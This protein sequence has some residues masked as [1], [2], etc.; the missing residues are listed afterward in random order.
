M[1][2]AQVPSTKKGW[3]LFMDV[4]EKRLREELSEIM[5][6]VYTKGL[7]SS[8]GG[9]SSIICREDSYVLI[10][11]SGLDKMNVLPESIVKVNLDGKVLDGG[12]PSSELINHLAIYK[13][14][15][16]INAIVHAHPPTAVGM[17]SAGFVPKPVTPEYVVMIKKLSIVDFAVPGEESINK[18]VNGLKESDIVLLKNHGVF[19][20]GQNLFEAFARIEVLEEAAKM[21]FAGKLF[22]GM[23]EFSEE[24]IK[25]IIDKYVRKKEG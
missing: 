15:E 11:P 20:V 5:N 24:E 19:S 7:A 21:V 18:L 6:R 17:V 10:T 4:R 22:G 23:H 14:R 25:E 2:V 1:S 16:D 3:D 12:V 8:V 13:S 9:N